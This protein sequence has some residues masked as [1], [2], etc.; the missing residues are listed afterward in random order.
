MKEKTHFALVL[1]L[2]KIYLT[3]KQYY[4]IKM[5]KLVNNINK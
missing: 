2:F 4:T 3:N 5:H 1:I